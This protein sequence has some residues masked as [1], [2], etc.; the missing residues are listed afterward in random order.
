MGLFVFER[1]SFKGL[2]LLLLLL[3]V[4]FPPPPLSGLLPWP[5]MTDICCGSGGSCLTAAFGIIACLSGLP[6]KFLQ[7]E[8]LHVGVQKIS[9]WKHSQYFLRH[10]DRL[11][12]QPRLRLPSSAQLALLAEILG[13]NEL[14]LRSSVAIMATRRGSACAALLLQLTHRHDE[15]RQ[16]RPD[17]KHSQ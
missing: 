14:G 17:A 6:A 4:L 11:Q 13:R 16:K 8:H 10:P 1:D 7:L 3:L 5:P 12:W 9:A 15:G 2:L